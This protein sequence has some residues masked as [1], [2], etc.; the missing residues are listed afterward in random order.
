MDA[1]VERSAAF[2]QSR[3]HN[4][5][6]GFWNIFALISESQMERAQQRT[7]LESLRVPPPAARRGF[8]VIGRSLPVLVPVRGKPF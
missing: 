1:R 8:L 4:V 5:V 2:A 3:F 7:L 6:F